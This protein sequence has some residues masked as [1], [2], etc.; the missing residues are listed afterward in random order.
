MNRYEE[1]NMETTFEKLG[2][3][4][5]AA[6]NSLDPAKRVGWAPSRMC[7]ETRDLAPLHRGIVI[8]TREAAHIGKHRNGKTEWGIKGAYK[9]TGRSRRGR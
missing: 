3:R 2:L 1:L 9:G 4:Q 7:G 8:C 6:A 5:H